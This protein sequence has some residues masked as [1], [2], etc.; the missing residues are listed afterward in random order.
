MKEGNLGIFVLI[1]A[2]F[3]DLEFN[4]IGTL[5][6]VCMST[7]AFNNVSRIF[8]DFRISNKICLCMLSILFHNL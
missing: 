8:L 7:V 4:F 3:D 5:F 6:C 1:L 2:S